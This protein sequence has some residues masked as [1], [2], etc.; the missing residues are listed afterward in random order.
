MGTTASLS[1][2]LET[3]Q[4]SSVMSYSGTIGMELANRPVPYHIS[5]CFPGTLESSQCQELVMSACRVAYMCVDVVRGRMPPQNLQ[6]AVSPSCM[7]RL[8]TMAYL[9]KN[10]MRTHRELKEQLCY[11]P[12]MPTL[13]NGV[14]VSPE[15]TEFV[16]GATIGQVQYWVSLVFR[17][18]SNRWVCT[19]ADLG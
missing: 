17:C 18:E 1:D 14:L 3:G 12:V 16:V 11:L 7:K 15:T 2:E 13:I 10:H 19:T 4:Y 8:E 6:R 5:R 9:L